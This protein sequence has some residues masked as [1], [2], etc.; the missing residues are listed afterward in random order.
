MLRVRIFFA[1]CF[2]LCG[3]VL[4]AESLDELMQLH[5]EAIGGATRLEALVAMRA[6]GHVVT[7]GQTLEFELIAQ[8]PNRVRITM[9]GDGRTLVQGCDGTNA[10]WRWEPGKSQ[11]AAPMKAAE[12]REFAADAEFDDPLASSEDRGYRLDFAGRLA[13]R[14]RQVMKI[15]VTRRDMA[16]AFLLVDPDTFFIVARL[17]SRRL[18]SG[19]ELAVETRYDGYRPVAGVI[20]PHRV[21]TFVD[22]QR[23]GELVLTT[24]QSIVPPPAETF[25]LPAGT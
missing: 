3:G 13:W 25:T 4:R 21:E 2:Y 18:P 17:T 1:V 7:G 16:P 19:R 11:S 24:V 10:A 8:R 22:G 6:Q 23:T 15:L 12:G 14:D 9:R 5:R 20:L